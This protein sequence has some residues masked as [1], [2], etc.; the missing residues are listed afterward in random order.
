MARESQPDPPSAQSL[1]VSTLGFLGALVALSSPCSPE[2]IARHVGH[3]LDFPGR[4][5]RDALL[6]S[7]TDLALQT[8][9][10]GSN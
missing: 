2:G 9:T 7:G 3:I 10:A 6:E 4:L 1:M 8:R 5:G